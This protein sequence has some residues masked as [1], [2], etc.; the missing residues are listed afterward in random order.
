VLSE[1]EERVVA[2]KVVAIPGGSTSND[3]DPQVTIVGPI[4]H[5]L[6]FIFKYH[7]YFEDENENCPV[8]GELTFTNVLAYRWI[9]EFLEYEEFPEHREDGSL[10]VVEV[11]DSRYIEEMSTKMLSRFRLGNVPWKRLGLGINADEVKHYRIGVDDHGQYD[12]FCLGVIIKEIKG[13]GPPEL[14]NPSELM[15]DPEGSA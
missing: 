9:T 2:H 1:S 3:D 13:D 12:I 8:Y 15:R 4:D 5:P 7:A 11:L 10:G 6:T 14:F